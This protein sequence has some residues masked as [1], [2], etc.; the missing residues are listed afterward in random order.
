MSESP[1]CIWY[2]DQHVSCDPITS[3]T[4]RCKQG[5][6]H[7]LILSLVPQYEVV[8]IWTHHI[9]NVNTYL[10]S[11]IVHNL[12]RTTYSPVN[13]P[14]H[15][16][17]SLK[18]CWLYMTCKWNKSAFTTHAQDFFPRIIWDRFH[19][20]PDVNS[21]FS[22]QNHHFQIHDVMLSA[23]SWILALCPWDERL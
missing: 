22:T 11:Y 20:I 7:I 17:K 8:K 13:Q 2:K 9:W 15:W 5:P 10:S 19:L 12:K 3:A 4:Y 14:Q 6:K 21:L 18:L 23:S 16:N 1:V